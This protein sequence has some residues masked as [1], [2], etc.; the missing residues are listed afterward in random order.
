MKEITKLNKLAEITKHANDFFSY[1]DDNDRELTD[2]WFCTILDLNRWQMDENIDQEI[3]DKVWN[4][5][6]KS[7]TFTLDLFYLYSYYNDVLGYEIPDEAEFRKFWKLNKRQYDRVIKYF[8]YMD[9]ENKKEE[10][11]ERIEKM[12]TDF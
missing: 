6:N 4:Y 5:L 2:D 8:A 10:M 12:N 1:C 11:D 3:V 7:I 9:L